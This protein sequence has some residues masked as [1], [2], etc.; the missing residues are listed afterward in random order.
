MNKKKKKS[1]KKE[2]KKLNQN[3]LEHEKICVVFL[4]LFVFHK[5]LSYIENYN[6]KFQ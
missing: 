6:R 2:K 5:V 4:L 1:K 3:F